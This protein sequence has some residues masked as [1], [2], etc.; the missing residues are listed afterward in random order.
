MK[1]NLTP[2]HVEVLKIAL[3][4]MFNSDTWIRD[5]EESEINRISERAG[6]LLGVIESHTPLPNS[7]FTLNENR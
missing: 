4:E 6:Y 1:L 3:T 2:E 7:L 5:R